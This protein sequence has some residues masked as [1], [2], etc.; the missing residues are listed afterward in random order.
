MSERDGSLHKL[1]RGD[2]LIRRGCWGI[3]PVRVSALVLV[4]LA[5]VTAVQAISIYRHVQAGRGHLAVARSHL[6]E[7]GFHA[8]TAD[9]EAIDAELQ[10]AQRELQR[11][12]DLLAEDPLLRLIKLLPWAGT[13]LRAAES[14]LEAGIASAD[15]GRAVVAVGRAGLSAQDRPDGGLI[16]HRVLNWMEQSQPSTLRMEEA[17]ARLQRAYQ[18]AAQEPLLPPL[19]QARRTLGQELPRAERFS[20]QWKAAQQLAPALAGSNEQRAYLL[21]ALN[22]GELLPGGGLVT[23]VGRLTVAGG[24]V[25]EIAMQDAIAFGEDWQRQSRQYV[26][27]PQPL[28]HYLL[29]DMTWNIAVALWSPDF[30]TNARRAMEFWT[31]GGGAPVDGVIGINLA[32]LRDLLA[33]T[34]PVRLDTYGVTLTETNAVL[35]LERLTRRPFDR[36]GPDR[37]AIVGELAR[38]LIP[39]LLALPPER[40]GAL[41]Q[42]MS[43][44]VAGR[45]LLLWSTRPQEQH[46]LALLNLDGGIRDL[47]TDYLMLVDG[48]VQSTKLNLII[49]PQLSIDV[50]LT[51]A[52]GAEHEAQVTYRNDLPKWSEGKDPGLVRQLM[53]GGVYGNYARIYVPIGSRLSA[54]TLD[55]REAGAEAVEEELGKRVFARFFTVPAGQARVIT[56]RYSTPGVLEIYG[57]REA[58]YALYLQKQPGATAIA[59]KVRVHPPP[60]YVVRSLYANGR[61]ADS[62]EITVHLDRDILI[63]ARLE[64]D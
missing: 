33:L 50:H 55:G 17:L 63:A 32:A 2:S 41:L 18:Q 12:R 23:A 61:S 47:P 59:V 51:A 20:G 8:S 58:G 48:S 9:L 37:K 39:R 24:E 45:H 5:S 27:P 11:V 36:A 10:S 64:R 35:E 52:G 21:L 44:L 16:T 15:F 42:T 13:Q 30:P 40:S 4:L 22:E 1:V 28:R 43:D 54:L 34:G 56:Y 38:A 57:P 14:L 31:L 60:G 26:K 7:A 62:N 3:S 19:A 29:R 53:L 25:R 46:A 49:A 6:L